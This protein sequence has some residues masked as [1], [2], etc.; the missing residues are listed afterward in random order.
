MIPV[1]LSSAHRRESLERL[2]VEHVDIL[3]VGGGVVGT[4]VALDAATRGLSVALVEA[5]DFAAGTSSRSSKLIHGGLRY[6]EMLDFGLVAEALSERGLLAQRIAPHLVRP[7]PFLYPLR[8]RVW[9][10]LYAGAGV[11]LYDA[12][13]TLSGNRG[14]VP[15]HRHLSRRGALKIVPSMRRD[16]LTGALLYHDAQVDDARH[17]M[18]LA[19]TAAAY[20][21]IVATRTRLISLARS[22]GDVCGATVR[23]EETGRTIEVR[24]RCVVNATGVWTGDIESMA[25]D[26]PD[27]TV[28]A[29]K[30]VHLV[31]PRDRIDSEVGIIMRTDSSVLFVIPWNEHWLIGTTDT[32]WKHGRDH[33]A[34]TAGDIDYLLEH[35]NRMLTTPLTTKDV[36][37]VFA[38]LRPLLTGTSASTA[39]LSREHAVSH[40]VRG[41]V[42]VAGGKYTTYRV[43]ASDA[44]NEAVKDLNL[45]GTVPAS[46]T[47][48]VPL[49]GADGYAVMVNRLGTIAREHHLDSSTVE[50]LLG[51][52]GSLLDQVLDASSLD[53]TLLEPLAGAPSYLRAEVRYAASHEGALHLDDVLTRRTRISFETADRGSAA[54][55]EAASIMASVLGWSDEQQTVELQTYLD[56]VQAEWMSQT[57]PDDA[58]ADQAR[59]HR[60]SPVGTMS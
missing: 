40:R 53:A 36:V 24:A 60:A 12:M 21:A 6:L 38:G 26:K 15:W 45:A 20:G 14:G 8:H 39:K 48:D 31:V 5:R 56:R 27:F 29:S 19:R 28:R 13:A 44:V 52:Y 50:H 35:V 9:E 11:A 41:L 33:P 2:A 46:C 22:S 43:M 49:L 3:V 4:G 17:T 10:R 34:S 47:A 16:A 30:G 51:R 54:A 25:L 55:P 37:G 18:F 1:A 7:V 57:M 59:Y 32:D 23:D 42:S 58:S